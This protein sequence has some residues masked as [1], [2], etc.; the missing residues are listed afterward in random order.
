MARRILRLD[1]DGGEDE[2]AI[3]AMK[4]YTTVTTQKGTSNKANMITT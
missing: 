1:D 3:A 2:D 4:D